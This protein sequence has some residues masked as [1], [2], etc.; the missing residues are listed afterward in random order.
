MLS[1]CPCW[2]ACGAQVSRPHLVPASLQV[3]EQSRYVSLLSHCMLG[4]NCYAATVTVTVI[5]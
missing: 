5:V 3:N 2:V 1:P 4:I